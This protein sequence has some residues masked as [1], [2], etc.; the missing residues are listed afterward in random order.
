MPMNTLSNIPMCITRS[1]STP[2]THT[3]NTNRKIKAITDFAF[4]MVFDAMA[5]FGF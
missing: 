5:V 2:A 4:F 1:Y 3:Q